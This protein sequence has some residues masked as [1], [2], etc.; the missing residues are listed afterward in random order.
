M[1][2]EALKNI[3][4]VFKNKEGQKLFLE[5][6]VFP[7]YVNGEIIG[8]QAFFEN[9]SVREKMEALVKSKENEALLARHAELVPGL[10]FQYKVFPDGRFMFPFASRKIWNIFEVTPEEVKNDASKAFSRFNPDDRE[11]I[12]VSIR[13]SMKTL[14]DWHYEFK[15]NLP[16]N[17]KRWLSGHAKPERLADGST[18]WHGFVSDVTEAKMIAEQNIQA[19]KEKEVLLKEVHHRVKNNL[20]VISSILN[21]QSS[22]VKDESTVNVLRESQNRIKSMAFI[23][24]SLYQA[25]DFSSINFSDYVVNLLQNLMQ[26]YSKLNQTV[27]LNVDLQ[28][29]FLN[30]DSAIPCGLVINEIISNALKY[31]FV[32]SKQGD[33]ISISMKLEGENIKLVIGDNGV[34]LPPNIDYKNTESLGLQLV[35][36]LVGQLNGTLELD[37][38]KGVKYTILFA[39]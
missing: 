13:E 8:T 12:M 38:T 3:K 18:L 31:A 28:T 17:G 19:L 9:I 10:I 39:K 25:N 1:K 35:V 6:N 21:L 32:K 30:L 29:I 2:G 33:K 16:I 15:V 23:H 7:R 11:K 4:V 26:S 14:K 37:N 34:G 22:Y 5:G 24:E 36:T 27:K 20:Q